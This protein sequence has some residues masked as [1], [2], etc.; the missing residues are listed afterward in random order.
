MGYH[1]QAKLPFSPYCFR[2]DGP[3]G[4]LSFY[5]TYFIQPYNL[6]SHIKDTKLIPNLIEQPLPLPTNAVL[7]KA[8]VTSLYTN[9]AH[10]GG[11]A[12]VIHLMKEYMHLIPK[13][14]PPP[15]IVR[16]IR[17]VFFNWDSLH[18]RLNSHCKA[19]SYKK[20]KHKKITAYRKSV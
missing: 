20:K 10:D 4:H 14:C 13:N 17:D 18:A 2:C 19:W 16:G 8:D 6:P 3:T 5:I 12:S 7:L 11:I 1:S 15:H 9:V